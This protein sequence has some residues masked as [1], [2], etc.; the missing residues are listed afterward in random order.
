MLTRIMTMLALVLA[1]GLI[2]AG[3]GGDDDETTTTSST[4]TAAGATGATGATGAGTGEPLSQDEFITQAD[5]ACAAADKAIDEAAGE[6]FSGGGQPS[7]QEQEQFVT[8]SVVPSFEDTIEDIKALTPPEG[9]EDQIN[10]FLDA[11]EQALT[12]IEDDPGSI[13]EEGGPDD[14]FAEVNELAADYG[15]KDCAAE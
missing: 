14:P 12:E 8:D 13:T 10:E 4:T 1:A 2:A 6:T 9:D 11:A 15:L 7:K 3:C 5:K